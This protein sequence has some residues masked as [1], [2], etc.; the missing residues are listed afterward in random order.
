MFLIMASLLDE[1][2]LSVWVTVFKFGVF[3]AGVPAR[4]GNGTVGMGLSIWCVGA[5]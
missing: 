1:G 3:M 5:L 2:T 4:L